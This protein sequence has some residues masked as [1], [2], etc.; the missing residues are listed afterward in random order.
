MTLHLFTHNKTRQIIIITKTLTSQKNK[1][2]IEIK[3]NQICF[4]GEVSKWKKMKIVY[5][6]KQQQISRQILS[7]DRR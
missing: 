6:F 5:E 1:D 7:S 3:K 2:E 4:R